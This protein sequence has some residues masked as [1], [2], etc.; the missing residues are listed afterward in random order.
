ME[1]R[2]R[3]R[4]QKGEHTELF[5]I[6]EKQGRDHVT[7]GVIARALDHGDALTHSLI[8]EAVAAGGQA[9]AS[10]VN[11][12]DVEA[13]IIGG[14]LGTRLGAP[15]AKRIAAAMQPHLFVD[16]DQSVQVVP[17]GL[18]DYA[19]ALGA[20]TAAAEAVKARR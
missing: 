13:V 17:A 18:G 19:G 3:A 8:D 16:G 11:V 2:A 1:R 20:A 12:L 15:F 4:V 6:M 9:L 7:S 14:G 10:V 5:K